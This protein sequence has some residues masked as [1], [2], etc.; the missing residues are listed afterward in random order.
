M[1]D[2]WLHTFGSLHAAGDAQAWLT[3]IESLHQVP[4]RAYHNLT[5]IEQCLELLAAH[6]QAAREPALIE[7][8]LWF[9]DCIYVPGNTDNEV[10]SAAIGSE[11][12]RAMGLSEQACRTIEKMILATRHTSPPTTDDESLLV[13]IDM[14][15]LAQP[16]AAY[17][18][19]TEQIRSEFSFVSD[20]AFAAGRGK[21]LAGLLQHERIFYSSTFAGLEAAA[22]GNIRAELARL[23]GKGG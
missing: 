1:R 17:R 22:R 18:R 7:L 6:R 10:R 12:A 15:I 19:Y 5:H 21:F 13:D 4:A 3:I 14:S 2:R 23:E 9:H 20:A 11:A 16:E 8:A